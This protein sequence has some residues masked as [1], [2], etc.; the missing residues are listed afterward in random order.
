MLS[1]VIVILLADTRT[2]STAFGNALIKSG[3]VQYFGEVLHPQSPAGVGSMYRSITDC[4]LSNLL[5]KAFLH[6]RLDDEIGRLRDESQS[7]HMM[8]DIKYHDLD[9]V[10]SHPKILGSV[11]SLLAYF[12]NRNFWVVHLNRSNRLAAVISEAAVASNGVHHIYETKTPNDSDRPL[13]DVYLD[14]YT[15]V[16]S[17]IEREN[18]LRCVRTWLQD[19]DRCID[20]DYEAAF[21][22]ANGTSSVAALLSKSLD[23]PSIEFEPRTVHLRER[24]RQAIANEDQ[25]RRLFLGTRWELH[26][27]EIASNGSYNLDSQ[28]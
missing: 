20:V 12:M 16:T 3:R 15:T 18:S 5:D 27:E 17:L 2:G 1:T 14:P 4:T 11:P 9:I 13:A 7:V 26:F 24:F 10:P 28:E 8:L 25:M 21:L 19:Y 6:Q 22:S 23:D